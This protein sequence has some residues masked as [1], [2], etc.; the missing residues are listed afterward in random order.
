MIDRQ[1]EA[2]DELDKLLL[3]V[4]DPFMVAIVVRLKVG[5]TGKEA[6]ALL[7]LLTAVGKAFFSRTE[8]LRDGLWIAQTSPVI[9]LR[10]TGVKVATALVAAILVT[11]GEAASTVSKILL[12]KRFFTLRGE[13]SAGPNR[14]FLVS[15]QR[16]PR[17][18]AGRELF[19]VEARLRCEVGESPLRN[20]AVVRGGGGLFRT[21]L[22][23]PSAEASETRFLP[24]PIP[25][26][27][28]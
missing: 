22:I 25:L 14:R 2:I 17:L 13:L 23:P 15:S 21:D 4:L 26:I 24:R 8:L 10:R 11:L 28:M 9:G 6:D 5:V 19:G 3:L 27:S 18:E 7:P 20:S 1:E 16:D 12:W